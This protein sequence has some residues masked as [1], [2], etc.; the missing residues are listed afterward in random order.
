MDAVSLFTN[1]SFLFLAILNLYCIDVSNQFERT[2]I[3]YLSKKN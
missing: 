2:N 3:V 1:T